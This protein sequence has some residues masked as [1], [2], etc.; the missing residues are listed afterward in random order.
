MHISEGV[1]KPEIIAPAAAVSG[2]YVAYLLYKLKANDIPKVASMSALFFA[3]SFIH[4][5]LGPSSI[6]LVLSG[7]LGAIL[8]RNAFLAIFIGLLL[9]AIFFAFGGIGVLGVNSIVIG[10]PAILGYFIIHTKLPKQLSFFLVGF[11]P[12]FVSSILLSLVLV[13]NGKIFI[14]VAKLVFFAN[15]GLVFIEGLIS[16][17]ILNF[18]YK[19]NKGLIK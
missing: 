17:V 10:L 1:L 18:I 9:Q 7:I 3:A 19:V 5:P 8:G 14:D 16:F 2:I 4:F 11:V 15:I 6:H 13:L 12:I